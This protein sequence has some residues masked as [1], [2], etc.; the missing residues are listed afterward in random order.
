[1]RSLVLSEQVA[2][3]AIDDLRESIE[4][5]LLKKARM[6]RPQVDATAIAGKT[7]WV[8]RELL[9]W[10]DLRIVLAGQAGALTDFWG[11]GVMVASTA[12]VYVN[13]LLPDNQFVA[14]YGINIR[15]TNPATIK[16]LF[17]T[18]AGASTLAA[19]NVERLYGARVPE[20]I[21]PEY[22]YY[23]GGSTIQ[24]QLIPDTVGKAVGA[25]GVADHV[26]LIGLIA[27]PAGEVVSF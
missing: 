3:G 19:W 24:V 13:R 11:C 9:P 14:I 15:D 23:S 10:Q 20:G 26:I 22:M 2:P 17:Q 4:A 21:T 27:M 1:M 18:G 16:T 8:T 25:D 5:D 7:N 6:A 12:I